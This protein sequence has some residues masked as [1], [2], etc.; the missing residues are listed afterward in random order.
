MYSCQIYGICVKVW[1]IFVSG[2][3]MEIIYEV[4]VAFGCPL[5]HLC[6]YVMFVWPLCIKGG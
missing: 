2:T 1:G 6:K 4:D 5:A 3:Y